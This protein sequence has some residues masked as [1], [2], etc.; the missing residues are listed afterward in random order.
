[1][2]GI[3]PPSTL[4]YTCARAHTQ[5]GQKRAYVQQHACEGVRASTTG[6]DIHSDTQQYR[7]RAVQTYRHTDTQKSMRGGTVK[8]TKRSDL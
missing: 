5:N 3:L 7:R 6:T 1:L 2:I 4:V 8:L